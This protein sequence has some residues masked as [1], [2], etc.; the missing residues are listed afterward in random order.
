MYIKPSAPQE[1]GGVLD[2]GFTLYRHLLKRFFPIGF[3]GALLM[4]PGQ[5]LAQSVAR[6]GLSAGGFLVLLADILFTVIVTIFIYAIM[7]FLAEEFRNGRQ[8]GYSDGIS[9]ALRRFF[10]VL[11]VAVV[12]GLALLVS[13]VVMMVPLV[14]LAVAS[15]FVLVIV[16]API[17]FI[18]GIYIG[19]IFSFAPIAA[20]LE[21]RG[22]GG[23]FA[24]SYELV[25]GRWWRT[26]VILTVTTIIL[27]VG[28][29]ILALFTLDLESTLAGAPP[30]LSPWWADF[31]V[32]PV[33]NGLLAPLSVTFGIA[34]YADN[35]LRL[36][37]ADL[38]A[39]VAAVGA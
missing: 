14:A 38:S 19:V 39:R 7:L 24:Y 3:L 36:E 21:N 20:L 26:A 34:L 33:L 25:K 13:A 10:L 8:A 30:R 12:Y 35:K 23:S 4:A 17:A 6:E 37:G 28:S 27:F 22:F 29:S 32:L 18:P 11:A 15:L 31:I 5:R 9:V 16:L 1:I 2:D